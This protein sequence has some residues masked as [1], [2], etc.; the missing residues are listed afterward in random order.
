MKNILYDSKFCPLT[1]S[2]LKPNPDA[3]PGLLSRIHV[4]AGIVI[5]QGSQKGNEKLATENTE[6]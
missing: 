6:M 3:E 2:L 5:S 1:H 4:F